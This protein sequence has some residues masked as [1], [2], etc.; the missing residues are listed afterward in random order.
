MPAFCSNAV[1]LAVLWYS[2]IQ[3]TMNT[4]QRFLCCY[5][6]AEAP[7]CMLQQNIT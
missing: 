3:N 4:R 1:K 6:V 5:A 7:K 2:V